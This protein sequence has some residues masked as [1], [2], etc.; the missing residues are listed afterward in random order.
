M[1]V[2]K[3]EE[4]LNKFVENKDEEL[5]QVKELIKKLEG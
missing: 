4:H 2:R 1:N 5:K 3:E